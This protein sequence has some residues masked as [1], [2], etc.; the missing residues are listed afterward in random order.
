MNKYVHLQGIDQHGMVVDALVEFY[1]YEMDPDPSAYFAGDVRPSKVGEFDVIP[2][3]GDS[4]LPD[5]L[6]AG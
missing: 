1:T 2:I 6:T 5:I 4:G 3:G